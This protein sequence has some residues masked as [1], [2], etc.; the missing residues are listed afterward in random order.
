[1]REVKGDHLVAHHMDMLSEQ[2]EEDQADMKAGAE[3]HHL[4][5]EARIMELVTVR[6]FVFPRP[7]FLSIFLCC[8]LSVG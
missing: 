4:E 3:Q 6:F 8:L 1:M 2:L 7:F 5:S